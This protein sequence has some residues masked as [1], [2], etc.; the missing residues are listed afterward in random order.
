MFF[1]QSSGEDQ[2]AAIQGWPFGYISYDECVQSHHLGDELDARVF[3]RTIDFDA[4]VD[5]TATPDQQA[6]SQQYYY[7]M[8]KMAEKKKEGFDYVQFGT[9]DDN[10]FIPKKNREAKKKELMATNPQMYRQV[11]HG[12]FVSSSTNVFPTKKIEAIW[13][14]SLEMQEKPSNPDDKYLLSADWG[15]SD[16]GDPTVFMVFLYK[17]P[18]KLKPGEKPFRIVFHQKIQGGSPTL[19]LAIAQ[20]L[21]DT[22][23]NAEFVGDTA[24]L[25]GT[26]IK[27]L[28]TEKGVKMTDFTGRGGEKG[29]AIM[30]AR[31]F[32][33]KEMVESYYIN[34]LE[35]QLGAYQVDDKK[36]VQDFVVVF[37]QAMWRFERKFRILKKKEKTKNFKIKHGRNM[38]M[39]V[40]A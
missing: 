18:E 37:Y 22:W 30:M 1:G 19:Q 4:P 25:G 3:S 20:N 8:V 35:E 2:G 27:K 33:I 40:T 36:L 38:P 16:T 9:L 11:V 21:K 23:N 15:G 34:D 28:L 14:E 24:A 29:D 6:K 13:E 39:T 26:W 5:L 10:I 17:D 31:D 12:D 7:H 32:V